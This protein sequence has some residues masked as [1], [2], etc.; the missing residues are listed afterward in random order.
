MG[1]NHSFGFWYADLQPVFLADIMYSFEQGL[2]I[3]LRVCNESDVIGKT[4]VFQF[5]AININA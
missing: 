4:E 1:E 5:I 3:I 2:S